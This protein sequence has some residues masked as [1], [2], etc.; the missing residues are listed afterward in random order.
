MVRQVT[1]SGVTGLALAGA[2]GCHA[3]VVPAW[4]FSLIFSPRVNNL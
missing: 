2:W 3:F 4:C 1:G